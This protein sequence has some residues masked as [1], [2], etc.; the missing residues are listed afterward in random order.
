MADGKLS[1]APAGSLPQ[2]ATMAP[3][4]ALLVPSRHQLSMTAS[5]R[6]SESI[7]VESSMVITM[8]GGAEFCTLSGLSASLVRAAYAGSATGPKAMRPAS[9]VAMARRNSEGGREV[10][11][12]PFQERSAQ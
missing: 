10:M 4:V 12:V 9:R 5:G 8:L 7:D 6:K 1:V 3:S 2:D 11:V